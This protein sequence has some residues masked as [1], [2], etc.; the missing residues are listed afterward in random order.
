MHKCKSIL[1]H[2]VN[3]SLIRNDCGVVVVGGG[4]GGGGGGSDSNEGMSGRC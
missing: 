3:L 4:G 2:D 1:S